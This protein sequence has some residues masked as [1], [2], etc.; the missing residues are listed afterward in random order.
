MESSIAVDFIA[1]KVLVNG[2]FLERQKDIRLTKQEIH[3]KCP[4]CTAAKSKPVSTLYS[5]N[6][7]SASLQYPILGTA[8]KLVSMQLLPLPCITYVSAEI[9]Q[10]MQCQRP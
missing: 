6:I 7:W 1:S 9:K 4:G 10:V 2:D 5:G 8:L 3:P